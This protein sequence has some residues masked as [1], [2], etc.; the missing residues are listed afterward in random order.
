MPA[1]PSRLSRHIHCTPCPYIYGVLILRKQ[2]YIK[3]LV[4]DYLSNATSCRQSDN[5]TSLAPQPLLRPRAKSDV[6]HGYRPLP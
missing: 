5:S 6:H 4:Y 1:G 3:F 2:R